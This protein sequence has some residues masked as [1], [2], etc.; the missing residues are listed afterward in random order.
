MSKKYKGKTCVYCGVEG[1]SSTP[2][3]VLAR[4]FVLKRHRT[5]LPKVPACEVCNNAKSALETYLTAVLPF[6]GHHAHARETLETMVP[7]RLEKNSKVRREL[8]VSLTP[9]WLPWGN[10]LV[11]KTRSVVIDAEKYD[12]WA[13][14]VIKGLVWHHWKMIIDSAY[15]L[16]VLQLHQSGNSYFEYIFRTKG[17]RVGVTE[18][19]GG[20]FK[21]EAQGV[22]DALPASMWRFSVYGGL[23]LR[24]ETLADASENTWVVILPQ[25]KLTRPIS[26]DA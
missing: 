16:E 17:E 13:A 23:Q 12:L 20:A 11:R 1:A 26:L 22:R 14:M 25:H 9:R 5:S 18:L 2:D 10:G 4:E 15:S 24:G 8:G 7:R 21:Y 3:H 19:G 6:G